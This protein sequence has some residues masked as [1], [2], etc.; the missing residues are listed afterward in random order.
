MPKTGRPTVKRVTVK[1]SACDIA[2]EKRPSEVARNKTGRFFCSLACRNQVGSKPRTGT[3]FACQQCGTEFYRKLSST[4]VYCSRA[5]KDADWRVGVEVRVC[6][7]CGEDFDFDLKMKKFN[8]G[9]F[10][11]TACM[12]SHRRASAIG[13]TKTNEQGYVLVYRPDVEGAQATGW[14]FEHR[15]VMADMIGRPLHDHEN[16]HH[17]NGDRSDN[18]PANLELWSSWQPSGQ[19]VEDKIEWAKALIAEYEQPVR[20]L[21]KARK[22]NDAASATSR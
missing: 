9:K 20:K 12:H 7:G 22:A 10:C 15:L 8:A 21:R 11:S 3:V 4:Q 6:I 2:M 1:C 13:R 16:V 17:K 5:C 18:S 19:N 14:I